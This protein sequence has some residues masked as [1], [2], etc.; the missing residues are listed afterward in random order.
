MLGCLPV[1]LLDGVVYKENSR[2]PR[3]ECC[4]TPNNSS[5][6]SERVDVILITLNW[7]MDVC[8]HIL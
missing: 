3:L 7:V 6:N 2:G 5:H 8:V 4:G 1:T